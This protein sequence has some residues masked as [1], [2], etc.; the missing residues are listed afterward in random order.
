MRIITWNINSLRL[1]MPLLDRLCQ[2]TAPDMVC[3]QETK[4][5]T[6]CFPW[7]RSGR[8]DLITSCSGA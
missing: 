2:D 6:P 5:P 4:V 1:R 7:N 3:L 8:W